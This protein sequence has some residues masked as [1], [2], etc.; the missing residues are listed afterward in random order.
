MLTYN[1]DTVDCLTNGAFGEVVEFE[2]FQ[3]GKIHRVYVHFFNEDCGKEWRK[4]NPNIARKFP[5]KNIV[6][7]DKLEFNYSL[8]KKLEMG[9]KGTTILQ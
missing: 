1:V 5:N 9:T 8:S 6:A 2:S 4:R 3:S 7:I